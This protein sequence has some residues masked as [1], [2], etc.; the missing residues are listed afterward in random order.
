MCDGGRADGGVWRCGLHPTPA[1]GMPDPSPPPPPTWGFKSHHLTEHATRMPPGVT[2]TASQPPFLKPQLRLSGHSCSP[3]RQ[4]QAAWKA[5]DAAPAGPSARRTA[6]MDSLSPWP[7]SGRTLWG[8]DGCTHTP[9]VCGSP[10]PSPARPTAATLADCAHRAEVCQPGASQGPAVQAVPCPHT[11]GCR[12]P[13]PPP[14]LWRSWGRPG[15]C[16]PS[17]RRLRTARAAGA[18]WRPPRPRPPAAAA[19]RT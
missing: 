17:P 1:P 18:G 12:G 7:A 15:R 16:R 19:C 14:Y 10:D 6:R 3:V 2:V 4:H 8:W 5:P 13:E 9:D 11:P